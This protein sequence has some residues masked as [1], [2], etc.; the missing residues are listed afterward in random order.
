MP[1]AWGRWRG[2][3]VG[4]RQGSA[5]L[6][7]RR[8]PQLKLQLLPLS[9]LSRGVACGSFQQG[10]APFL[11]SVVLRL[12]LIQPE[13]QEVVG[14]DANRDRA[15]DHGD[16]QHRKQ[17]LRPDK[18]GREGCEIERWVSSVFVVDDVGLISSEAS[19]FYARKV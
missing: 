4:Q 2:T 17:Q 5:T 6:G 11:L 14:T 1:E 8:R 13:Y 18:E 15:P 19:P 12:I 3:I 10:I 16:R 9:V 7:G